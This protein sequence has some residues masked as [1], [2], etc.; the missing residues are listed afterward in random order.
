MRS[1]PTVVLVLGGAL[2]LAG[3]V[4]LFVWMEG[5]AGVFLGLGLG[6][7]CIAALSMAVAGRW[8]G[9]G[10]DPLETRKEQSLWRSGPLGRWWLGRRRRIP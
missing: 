3:T 10:P 5:G 9:T 2:F 4:L 8:L 1:T 7:I 6:F